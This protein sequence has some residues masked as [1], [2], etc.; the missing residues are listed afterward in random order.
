MYKE[1]NEDFYNRLLKQYEGKEFT[2]QY[3]NRDGVKAFAFW[4][5]TSY[6][7]SFTRSNNKGHRK[8]TIVCMA[9][10][11]DSNP[12][13]VDSM[14]LLKFSSNIFSLKGGI[15][16]C[17]CSKQR[18][19]TLMQYHGIDDFI[20]AT[21]ST[22]RGGT[23]TV[24]ECLGGKGNQRKYIMECSICCLDT[25]LWPYGILT[26]TKANFE[27]ESKCSC[28]CNP[29]KVIYSE[30]QNIVRVSRLCKEKGLIFKGW[31]GGVYAGTNKT[32]LILDCPEHGVSENTRL[33]KF[34]IR[35]G[36][37]RGCA[38][39]GYVKYK[40]RLEETDYLYL[41]KGVGNGEDFYKVGRS[42]Y[43]QRRLKQHEQHSIYS[44]SPVA[45]IKDTHN[46]IYDL[47]K[48]I[49]KTTGH[50]WYK[51]EILWAGG[52]LECRDLTFITHPEVIKT[53]NL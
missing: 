10:L 38:S 43:P 34:L 26:S 11:C 18:G 27:V 24:K 12:L 30:K 4:D 52:H 16:P 20:G 45:L 14:R 31:A 53:F 29:S 42:F 46:N 32:P 41:L 36:G 50:L 40:D 8:L 15:F 1:S 48:A 2:Y 47:E 5:G 19:K 49:L 33:G 28:G 7:N 35:E 21:K 17:G 22:P 9:C 25:E 39:G 44:F 37:C 13:V 6:Y 3:V 23:T 51:P